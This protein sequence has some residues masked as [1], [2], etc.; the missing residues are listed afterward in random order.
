MVWNEIHIEGKKVLIG[1]IYAPPKNVKQLYI[2]DEVLEKLSSK[3]PMIIGDFN[4][5]NSM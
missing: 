3:D 4:A 5:R 2:L 1:N